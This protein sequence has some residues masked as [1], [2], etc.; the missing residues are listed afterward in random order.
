[1][2]TTFTAEKCYLFDGQIISFIV[3]SCMI[4]I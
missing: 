2:N 1:M 3:P 4:V